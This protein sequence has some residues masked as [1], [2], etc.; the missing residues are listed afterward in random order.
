MKSIINYL[1]RTLLPMPRVINHAFEHQLDQSVYFLRNNRIE[2]GR[3]VQCTIRTGNL[4]ND[5]KPVTSYKVSWG[6]GN[7][8]DLNSADIFSTKEELVQSLLKD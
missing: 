8:T 3:V 2:E 1:T 6:E 5:Y 4:F 7:E